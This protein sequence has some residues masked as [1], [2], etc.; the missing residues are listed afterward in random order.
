MRIS[1]RR[2]GFTLIELL[3]VIA[4]IAVLIALLLPAVQAA[5]EA[6]R[7]SQCINN[8]KQIGLALHNYHSASNV[9]PLGSSLA[10]ETTTS[11]TKWN[12]WGAHALM[13]P[14]MEQTAVYNAINFDWAARAS[15]AGDPPQYINSTALGI[16]IG[17]FL[18]PTDGNAGG[19]SGN[20]NSYY[21]S[22]GTTT[23]MNN[24][25]ST[26]MFTYQVAY[27]IR[28]C[29]DGTTN[30]I[31][32]SESLAGDS[33]GT[34]AK[35][36]NGVGLAGDVA[37]A[38]L[39]D[40]S[41]NMT[42]VNQALAGCN[43]SFQAGTNIFRD[44]GKY[45]QNGIEGYSMFNTVVTPNSAQ[46]KWNACRLDCCATAGHAHFTKASSLHSGGVNAMMGDGSVKF[47][48]STINQATWMALGT[49]SGGEVVS[50]DSY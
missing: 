34:N 24:T 36:G 25:G 7:R 3:V 35:P 33:I 6:A 31:A 39:I 48:K 42:A 44:S 27:G 20:N 13:L 21:G 11:Q 9:Y 16:K 8:L 14:Q 2:S 12:N 28:D 5:R 23:L 49:R 15:T 46:N 19:S 1:R 32:F 10:A 29:T 30:T 26:G 17:V 41:A 18:C 47:I 50:S 45:W 43:T 4:I 37:A 40:A 22:I 38:K